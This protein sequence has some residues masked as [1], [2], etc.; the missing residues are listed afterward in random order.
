M[1]FPNAYRQPTQA[2]AAT[3]RFA[4]GNAR[5]AKHTKAS[6]RKNQE[7]YHIA[8]G[9][10]NEGSWL[11][12]QKTTQQIIARPPMVHRNPRCIMAGLLLG[13]AAP[14]V[15]AARHQNQDDATSCNTPALA[16]PT[17]P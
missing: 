1:F 5:G 12:P 7:E 3:V 2:T 9:C 6:S 10:G 16:C 14:K 17:F 13:T 4:R 15:A 8:I 11:K